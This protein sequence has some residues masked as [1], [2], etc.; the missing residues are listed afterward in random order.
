MTK[1]KV[2]KIPVYKPDLSGNEKAYVD[3]CLDS[4]WISSKGE[5]IERF[6]SGFADYTGIPHAAAVTNGTV[7][8]HVALVALG[9]EPGDEVIVPALTYIASVNAILYVGATPVFVDSDPKTW[10]MDPADIK[11]KV[12]PRTKA[13]MVVHLY[14]QAC[15]MDAI[16]KLAKKYKLLVIE[17]CAEAIGT[18][19]KGQHV[20]TFG[21]I[22]TFSFFG[23]KTITCGEG[24]MVMSTKKPL[25][26]LSR[27][28]KGQGLAV[29]REYWHDL[30]GYNYRLTNTCAAIGV[31]Q[32]ERVNELVAAKRRLSESY[33]R[34]LKRPD[35][36]WHEEQPDST[37]SYWMITM[38]VKD[39]SLREGLREFL[40]DKG[41][42]T[43]PI[44]PPIHIM[45]M[46][47][48]KLEEFPVAA[49]LSARG[50]N[51]P[52]WPGLEDDDV[53][54]ITGHINGYLSTHG[55]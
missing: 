7:A 15:D 42:E 48:G 43:R 34:L 40:A 31:A 37:H 54:Y 24:G 45:P 1:P 8:L 20:G 21:D 44:F 41:I 22:A 27:R 9:I 39:G 12:T 33:R 53:A 6:E 38:L 11:R 18:R 26:D 13:I 28:L 55:G 3:Q 52:S 4:T 25:V 47:G 29:G 46:H 50:F 23:N 19:W 14:G 51:L 5:F 32:L 49:D 36:E 16:G 17:D 30:V 2:R 10:Q 35:I